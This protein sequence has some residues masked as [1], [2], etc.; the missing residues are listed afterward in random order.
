MKTK[1]KKQVV[2]LILVLIFV[3]LILQ[4]LPVEAYAHNWYAASGSVGTGDCTIGNECSLWE[5]VDAASNGDTI[6]LRYGPYVAQSETDDEVLYID[7]SLTII[8]GCNADY[9][10]CELGYQATSSIMDGDPHNGWSFTRVITIQGNES[11]RPTVVLQ[12]LHIARGD[13]YGITNELPCKNDGTSVT[14]GCGGGVY[15]NQ[16]ASLTIHN[17]MFYDN[18]GAIEPLA[19]APGA[20]YGGAIYLQDV[21]DIHLIDNEF[22]S[23]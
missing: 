17:C 2:V 1:N 6:F 15:A 10:S 8:G 4:P 3:N 11:Y 22:N 12:N 14:V 13:A 5:A 19:G 16:V 9:T 20:G 21:D 7:K 18:S 23:N